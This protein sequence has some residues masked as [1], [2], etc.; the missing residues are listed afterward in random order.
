MMKTMT[1]TALLLATLLATGTAD[2]AAQQR[3]RARVDRS[4]RGRQVSVEA[5]MRMRD[6]LELT[7]PQIAQLDAIRQEGV[8]RRSTAMSER[9]ELQ[10][11]VSAGQIERSEMRDQLE[12]RQEGARELADQQR[13]RVEAILSEA[14]RE[15]LD[16]TR[17]RARAFRAR[18]GAPDRARFRSRGA[19]DGRRFRS[20]RGGRGGR[21]FRDGRRPD[22]DRR[23]PPSRQRRG[24]RGAI[25]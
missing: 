10:S 23:G 22:R 16:Q 6:R 24:R 11:Q 2:L 25:G 18:R 13:E 19:P 12:T 1:G 4:P 9:A 8:Q 7:D 14:Q 15:S 3:G 17:S 20:G 5:I 21:S